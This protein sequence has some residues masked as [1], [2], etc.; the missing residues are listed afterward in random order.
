VLRRRPGPLSRSS[1]QRILEEFAARVGAGDSALTRELDSAAARVFEAFAR[2][3]VDGVLLKGAALAHLLY[4]VPEQ[5]RYCDVDVLVA[6]DDLSAARA[7]LVELGYRNASELV[8][9]DDIGEVIHEE[10][11]IAIPAGARYPV[12][13]EL[14]LRLAGAKAHA[15]RAWE[16]L[17]G[18]STRIELD[19]RQVPILD[20][21]GL[22]MHLAT[23]AAQ[24]GHGYLKGCRELVRALDRWS[25][26]VWR[27]AATLAG[28]IDATEAF[29]AGLRLVEPGAELAET[30]GLPP[31]SRLDWELRQVDRPRGRFHLQAFLQA[32]DLR[33]RAHVIRRALLPH[34]RWM[35]RQ[36][37][38]ARD[39]RVRMFAAYL[40]HLARSPALGLRV[41]LFRRRER[42]AERALRERPVRPSK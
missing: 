14:H 3:N 23:H 41:L 9:V 25:P 1:S 36:Y 11:W 29:A 31:T 21:A 8:A 40:L 39:G 42:R 4:D 30:L 22:A 7:A 28:D 10:T 12:V 13:V 19:G 15:E 2:G 18:R 34:P 33:T 20:R 37:P 6:P 32:G 24:H 5:R 35:V 38:W 26:E 16:A 27:D 17:K